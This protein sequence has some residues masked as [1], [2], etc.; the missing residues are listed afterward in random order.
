MQSQR[1]LLP[2]AGFVLALVALVVVR[3]F[4]GADEVSGGSDS[5][6]GD[7][8]A[9][10]P[11]TTATDPATASLL[12]GLTFTDVTEAAGLDEP[13]GGTA[14]GEAAMTAGAAVADVD[15]DGDL[16]VFLTRVGRANRLLLN[17]GSGQFE[18]ASERAGLGG[19][20]SAA[21]SSAAAFVDVDADGDLDLVVTGAGAASTSLLLNDGDGV[22]SDATTGSGLDDLPSLPEGRDA[23]MHGITVA[24]YDRDGRLD[25]LMTHWD[26]VIPAAL[27]DAGDDLRPDD[28]GSIVCARRDWLAERGFPRAEGAPANRG[29]LYRNEGG[30]R[31]RD[32]STELGL[33]FDEVLGFTGSFSDVD[34]DGWDDLL[35]TGDFCTSR[36]F[37][38]VEGTRFEDVTAAAGVG[39]DENGMGSVVTDLNG[40]GHPDWFVT[41]IG[42]V[43]DAPAPLS[44][45]GGFGSSG[46]RAYLNRGDGTFV[47]ATDQLGVRNGGWGWG[48]AIE[49]FGNDGRL[50]VV[51]TNG[52][53]IGEDDDRSPGAPAVDP[54]M[55][56]LLDDEGSTQVGEAAGLVDTG[57]GRALVPFDMDRDGDLDLLVA[58]HGDSPRLYRNDTPSRH[59]L[60]VQLDDPASPGNRHGVGA[61]VTVTPRG[62][63]PITRWI[64]GGGSYESQVPTEVHLGL[65]GVDE[66]ER[67]EVRWPDGAAQVVDDV[68]ADQVL[69]VERSAG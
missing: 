17:D 61:R 22:F 68:A 60:V 20:A 4:V 25:L 53:S 29:R 16:D 41:S 24:D 58:N 18:D 9:T 15:A 19:S 26:D 64:V 47:D 10:A 21:G 50:G 65:G 44:L 3:V 49:D 66:V 1:R 46:N 7:G 39:T 40:D 13:H 34:G 33:P 23:Q 57:L 35:L 51:M 37:R 11:S 54:L 5:G 56:W 36:L 52:Y 14:T 6:D 48:A 59:W 38:N 32:V 45:G 2:I 62:G 31:F 43:D 28:Q 42:P 69:V 12:D 63:E 30:G 8:A 27:A 67:V 55:L